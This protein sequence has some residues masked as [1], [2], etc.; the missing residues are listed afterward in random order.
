M[1]CGHSKY[2][3]NKRKYFILE[4]VWMSFSSG[5]CWSLC[6]VIGLLR[7]IAMLMPSLDDEDFLK[8]KNDKGWTK[9]NKYA[10]SL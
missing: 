5:F 10:C 7:H 9:Y 6:C 4:G 1:L 8:M 2:S 3:V